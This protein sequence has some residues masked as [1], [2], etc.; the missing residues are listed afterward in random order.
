[1]RLGESSV[2]GPRSEYRHG[3]G[4]APCSAL[5]CWLSLDGSHHL[6]TWISLLHTGSVL[7]GSNEDEEREAL[8]KYSENR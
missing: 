8:G 1:M 7:R 5:L 3:S 6:W 4:D 2:P